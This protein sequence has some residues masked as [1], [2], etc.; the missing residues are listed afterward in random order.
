MAL[1]NRSSLLDDWPSADI[2]EK[3]GAT[4]TSTVATPLFEC[5]LRRL[6]MNMWSFTS[7]FGFIP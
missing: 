5:L 2:K 3:A 7:L 6:N 1:I 4:L